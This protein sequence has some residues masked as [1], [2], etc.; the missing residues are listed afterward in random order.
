MTSLVLGPVVFKDYEIPESV[1]G[2]SGKQTTAK[3][4]L[5]GGRRVVDAMGPDDDDPHWSGRLQGGDATSRALLLDSLRIQGAQLPFSVGSF[6]ALVVIDHLQLTFERSYQILYDISVVVVSSSA[7]LDFG[8][9]V[10]DD[11]VNGD[12]SAAQG[13]VAVLTANANAVA[14]DL[15]NISE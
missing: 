8:V 9:P 3:H 11:L 2:L 4:S 1:H 5:L 15:S 7:G 10:L 13:A 12:I 6:F 14:S